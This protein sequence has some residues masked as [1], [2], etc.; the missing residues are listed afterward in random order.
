VFLKLLME[1]GIFA[2]ILF[3]LLLAYVLFIGT[4]SSLSLGNTEHAGM[5]RLLVVAILG[6][7]AHNLIDY[8]LQFMGIAV[9][10]WLS[11]GI[12]VSRSKSGRSAR[13]RHWMELLVAMLLIVVVVREG[14]LL[15][16]SSKARHEEAAGNYQ[17]ALSW[18]ALT[19]SALFPRDQWLA[20]SV[21][22][23]SL[24]KVDDARKAAELSRMQNAEDA[25]VWRLLGD[26]A[27]RANKMEDARVAYARAFAFGRYNDIGITRGFV[28]VT[29]RG[30]IRL[31]EGMR[32]EVDALL[33]AFGEAMMQNLHFI[34]LSTNVEDLASL[35]TLMG[36]LYP[37]DRGVYRA[38]S[39]EVTAHAADVR[40]EL[41]SRTR[42]LLW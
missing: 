30:G 4:R 17:S 42:G 39:D 20:R 38:L 41:S 25:R 2:P 16:Y 29:T 5:D 1:R 26:I 34:A 33:N 36:Q 27:L 23:L 10:L 35:T 15:F 6:V 22:L 18:Y 3:L 24:G 28:Y 37:G 9:V 11:F 12:I 7:L 32:K 8:N 14:V 21:I 40:S 31:E 13:F 19:D